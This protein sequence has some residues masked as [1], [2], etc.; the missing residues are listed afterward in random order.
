MAGERD[1]D[2]WYRWKQTQSPQDLDAL[3]QE[4]MPLIRT[5]ISRAYSGRVQFA[6]DSVLEH[7]YKT[8]LLEAFKNFDP[9]ANPGVPLGAYVKP[10]LKNVRDVVSTFQNVNYVPANRRQKLNEYNA[11]WSDLHMKLG[12]DPNA[13]ELSDYLKWPISEITTVAS[14]NRPARGISQTEADSWDSTTITMGTQLETLRFLWHDL[15]DEERVV[16]EYLYGL[17]GKPKLGTVSVAMRTGLTNS[18]VSRVK[19]K[20]ENM[21]KE[22]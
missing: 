19:K 11:A 8:K 12:R 13:G 21:I 18:K 1:L 17:N 16:F 15:N 6:T 10:Y 14:E 5:Q 3:F 4:F 2:L 7:I 9:V 22:Q 20:I